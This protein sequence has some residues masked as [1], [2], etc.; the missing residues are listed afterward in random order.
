MKKYYAAI[1]LLAALFIASSA[2]GAGY[3][4]LITRD[5]AVLFKMDISQ[6]VNNKSIMS[7][8]KGE[9]KKSL[10]VLFGEFEKKTGL[11]FTRDISQIGAFVHSG[12]DF[13]AASPNGICIF[14]SGKFD[15]EKLIA[16]IE[17]TGLPDDITIEKQV[18]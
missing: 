7:L 9:I 2:Y 18:I 14:V 10:D 5:P 8:Y 13:N 1:V 12:I 6:I 17:K 11:S 4:S 16:E 15:R 3:S